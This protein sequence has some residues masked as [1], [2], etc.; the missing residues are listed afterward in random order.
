MKPAILLATPLLPATEA[1]LEREFTCHRK[2]FDTSRAGEIRGV[3][4][5]NRADAA[6][7]ESLPNLEI[8]ASS[9]VGVDGVDLAAAKRRGIRVTNTPGVLDDC[10]AETA[11]ALML[12][13]VHR[14]PASERWLREGRWAAQGAFMLGS[15]LAGKTLGILGYGR[16]GE[17]IA[18]RAL[19]F[20]MTVRYHNRHRKACPHPYDE[21]AEALAR[22]SD[23]LLVATPGGDET[24]HL[25]DARVLEALGPEGWLVNIARGSVVD[26]AAL[27]AALRERRI[28]GAGIDVFLN[29]PDINPAFFTIENAV[30]FPHMGSASIETRIAMG[31]LM[32]ENLRRHFAGEPLA[33]P[34][35]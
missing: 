10:T 32:I 31:E 14:Y 11:L 5:F 8:I 21:S 34:F 30:L 23:I 35:G 24:R 6:L 7:I 20:G 3:A 12:N 2:G 33:T 19:A 13:V 29:E 4:T 16:I 25:V 27:L 18:Q 26:E 15:Q 1:T 9:T 17:A 28:R 22:N